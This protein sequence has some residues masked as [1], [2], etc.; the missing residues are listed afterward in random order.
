MVSLNIRPGYAVRGRNTT[1]EASD[2]AID[3]ATSNAGAGELADALTYSTCGLAASDFST[4]DR[5]TP[6][7]FDCRPG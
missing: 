1:G 3:T 4:L 5:S 6:G 7:L 2:D